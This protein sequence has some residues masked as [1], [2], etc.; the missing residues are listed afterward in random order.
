MNGFVT[1]TALNRVAT[2]ALAADKSATMNR[3]HARTFPALIGCSRRLISPPPFE[4][5][6]RDYKRSP[7]FDVRAIADS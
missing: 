5:F 4:G 6:S 7:R 3:A 1:L 2:V